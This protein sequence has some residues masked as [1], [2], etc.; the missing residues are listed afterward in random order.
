VNAF[1]P[2][3]TERRARM[4]RIVVLGIAAVM[5]M[6]FF[7]TQIVDHRTYATQSRDNRLRPI[8]LAAARGTIFDRK[9]QVLVELDEAGIEQVIRRYRR[10]PYQPAVVRAD[11]PLAMVA[12]LEERRLTIPGLYIQ[13]EPKRHYPDSTVAAH[14]LGY[15]G[16]VAESE[17]RREGTPL[18]IGALVGKDGLEREYD[19]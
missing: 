7:R 14:I 18:R 6:A 19:D 11:A 15:V 5:L 12:S 16:E 9:G 8:T 2:L 3:L 17:R 13:T 10:A 4:A 1:H